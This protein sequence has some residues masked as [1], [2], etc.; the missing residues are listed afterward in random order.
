MFMFDVMTLPN[1]VRGFCVLLLAGGLSACGGFAGLV[2]IEEVDQAQLQSEAVLP[3]PAIGSGACPVVE[4]GLV[5]AVPMPPVR[6]QGRCGHEAPFAVMGLGGDANVAFDKEAK[7]NCVMIT[8]LYRYFAEDM[9]PA[10][11]AHLGAPVSE[12]TVAAS[13]AC[14]TR[15]HKRGGKLSE[16]GK[17]NAID[18]SRFTFSNG[19]TLTI[20]EDWRRGNRA[21]RFLR[22]INR[23]ACKY[24]TTVI[25]PGGDKYHQD[26]FHLDHAR[27]GKDGLWRVCQ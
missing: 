4:M 21:G 18:F 5:H 13:Y 3:D 7:L 15:N 11:V 27:H 26:H 19:Q 24:F 20:E 16:H 25:G 8:Q 1:W 6:D 9:Q 23:K 22:D 14:R 17:M 10:A 2:D 12:V